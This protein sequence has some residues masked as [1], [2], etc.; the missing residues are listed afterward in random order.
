MQTPGAGK[1][2]SRPG[3]TGATGPPRTPGQLAAT[4]RA[5]L[6]HEAPGGH[7]RGAD[8]GGPGP[9]RRGLR[10]DRGGGLPRKPGSGSRLPNQPAWSWCHAAR[11]SGWTAGAPGVDQLDHQQHRWPTAPLQDVVAI[12]PANDQGHEDAGRAA[13]AGLA[14]GASQYG[15]A[16]ASSS[17]VR[18]TSRAIWARRGS[19]PSKRSVSRRRAVKVRPT[20]SPYRSPVKSRT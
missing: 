17:R 7:R 16:S 20:W 3:S 19:S 14:A 8:H 11:S 6:R 2:C 9:S 15:G 13:E 1:T 12:G 10:R 18:A 5:G 4:H